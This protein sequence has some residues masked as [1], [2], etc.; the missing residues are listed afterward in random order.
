[1]LRL[2]WPWDDSSCGKEGRRDKMVFHHH[3]V[4]ENVMSAI[5]LDGT[6]IAAQIKGEV[7]EEVKELTAAGLRPGL[8]VV[9]A[10]HNPASEIYVRN[11]VKS[12]EQ[13]GIY[14]E[15]HT[16]A[17]SVT[18]EELLAL[19]DDLNRRDEIDGILVQLPLPPQVDAK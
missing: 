19:V 10:G 3:F 12:C 2:W 6:R 5:I 11:K 8:A 15:K 9:L 1:M 13:L 4:R 14:S 18:T 17:E 16:P 7:G